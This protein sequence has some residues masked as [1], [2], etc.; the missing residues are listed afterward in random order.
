VK[1]TIGPEIQLSA[2]WW[3][4]GGQQRCP[5]SGPGGAVVWA[6]LAVAAIAV[7]GSPAGAASGNAANGQKL[8]VKQNCATCHKIGNKGGKIGPDL[9]NE[10]TKRDA[11]WLVAFL[12]NPRSKVPK[13][14]MPAVQAKAMELQDLA[15]YMR[16]LK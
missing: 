2:A 3:R 1:K 12:K 9:S 11:K 7:A 4:A 6:A 15:A 10:G 5:G 14:S 8:Y 13:G 16:S